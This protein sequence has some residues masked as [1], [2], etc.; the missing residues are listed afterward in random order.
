MII[1]DFITKNK[2]DKNKLKQYG[3]NNLCYKKDLFD[4]LYVT[5][6]IIK[7]DCH[8]KVYDNDYK[9]EYLPFNIKNNIGNY[10]SKVKE[11]VEI[12]TQ[13]IIDKCGKKEEIINH[14]FDYVKKK[15]NTNP[16]LPF[17]DNTSY[18]LTVNDKWYALIMRIKGTSLGLNEEEIDVINLK[19]DPD[20]IN[21]IIDNKTIFRAYH[22][23]KKYWFTIILNK[24]NEKELFKYIDDSY[25]IVSKK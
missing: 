13:D 25:N 16:R 12:I 3:F 8:I 14:I 22:M 24:I 23:N 11:Q 19:N 10:V 21:D 1:K 5:Y 4:N 2:I 7:D 9:E 20:I 6:E 15:Y 18:V 17:K